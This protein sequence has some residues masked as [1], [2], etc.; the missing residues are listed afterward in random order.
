M[1][2]EWQERWAREDA[3]K[4]AKKIQK[5]KEKKL[6]S[7]RL[8]KIGVILHYRK[9]SREKDFV[10]VSGASM[11]KLETVKF[12]RVPTTVVTAIGEVRKH[13]EETVS[14]KEWDILLTVKI[15]EEKAAVISLGKLCEDHG[16]LCDWTSGK[17][18]NMSEMV[19]PREEDCRVGAR[20]HSPRASSR[21]S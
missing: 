15:L 3:W 16:Y 19:K 17:K 12:S 9:L 7:S 1:E 8:R 18:K 10:V 13:Q 11:H 21:R 14:V 5:L 20:H 2:T 6:H 4:V